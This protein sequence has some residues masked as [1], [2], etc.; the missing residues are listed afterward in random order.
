ME[1]N[2]LKALFGLKVHIN[3][4]LLSIIIVGCTALLCSPLSNIQ[5]YHI[6]SFILLFVVSIMATIMSV[7]PVL[8]MSTLSALVWNFMFIP[9]RLTFHIEKPEDILMFGMFFIIAFVNGVLTTRVRKQERL[10]R[11]REE[12]TNA[13]FVLTKKL[14]D[15]YG[16]VDVISVATKEIEI[17]FSLNPVFILVE[18]GGSLNSS[19]RLQKSDTLESN[20][21][22]IAEWAL[23][24]SHC[25]GRYTN[26]FVNE[27]NTFYPLLGTRV[28]TG[29]VVV[30]HNGSFSGDRKIFWDTFLTQISSALEREFL[31]E[32][33]QRAWLLDESDRLFKTLFNSISHELRIPVAT[34]L[35]AADT[36]LSLPSPEKVQPELYREIFTA[37]I[38]L[39]RLIENLLNMSRLESGRISTR[40][41][42]CDVNDLVSKIRED[43]N[44]ELELFTF[45]VSI[46]EDMPLV[47]I[48]FGLIEQV[49]Y[50]L[51]YNSCEY[52]PLS[53]KI[54][55]SIYYDNGYL[56]IKIEDSGPG[57]PE[58]AIENVFNKFFKVDGLKSGGLGLGLSI[59]KGFVEAHQG[60]IV[61]ENR[62][63]GG[64]A[65]TIKI[66][67]ETPSEFPDLKT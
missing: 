45:N 3:Q 57:F 49:L 60:T 14:S 27:A 47:K 1:K 2:N 21:N 52:T 42:W 22:D 39:N 48:D 40:L 31:G 5:S 56:V 55:L 24:N 50:N 38:R 67:S 54:W 34:I 32:I 10:A 58:S 4:Y 16:I 64:A 11:E 30:K 29:V 41:L 65:F 59:T 46:Q 51:I 25:A 17:T 23:N 28:N 44:E 35:G 6:V 9:P 66:P 15:S 8:L 61:L 36:L 12:R 19:Y 33:A 20:E 62:K 37:S 63:E 13:L 43:L 7:G 18:H 26:T 53:S